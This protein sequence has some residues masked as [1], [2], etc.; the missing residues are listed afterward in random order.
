MKDTRAKDVQA[1]FERVATDRDTMLREMARL[2]RPGGTVAITDEAEHPC[3]WM[4]E[5]HVDARLGFARGRWDASSGRRG[6][7]LTVNRL[8]EVRGREIAL[9][10]PPRATATC[11]L[12]PHLVARNIAS[13]PRFA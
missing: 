9:G 3:E 1:F 10:A 12:S 11:C 5:E 13:R 7:G 6:L 8:L 2:V 4:R